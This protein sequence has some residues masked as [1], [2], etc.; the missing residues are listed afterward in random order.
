MGRQSVGG[1]VQRQGRRAEYSDLGGL[2]LLIGAMKRQGRA[3][4]LL[5]TSS[6]LRLVA[7]LQQAVLSAVR[8][9]AESRTPYTTDRARSPFAAGQLQRAVR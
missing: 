2:G 4:V 6:F 7:E 8:L 9:S 1:C 5:R 3:S